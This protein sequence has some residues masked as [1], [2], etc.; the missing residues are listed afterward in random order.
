MEEQKMKKKPTGL[1]KLVVDNTNKNANETGV[2]EDSHQANLERF[3]NKIYS[4]I[5][6]SKKLE[7]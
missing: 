7:K 6:N 1:L 5:E 4:D 2:P 3:L